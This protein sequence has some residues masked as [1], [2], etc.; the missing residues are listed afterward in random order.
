MKLTSAKFQ[1]NGR[2]PAKYT[3]LGEDINPLLNIENIP[4]G[5]QSLVLI[6]DDPDAPRGTFVHWVV[7]DIPVI[8]QIKED[9][10]PGTQ[11]VNDFKTNG[12]GGPC[13]P[14]GTH[15]YF[16]KIYAL[17]TRLNLPAGRTKAEIE[18]AMKG[19]VIAQDECIGLFS[20]EARQPV[21]DDV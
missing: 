1:N 19:H 6:V 3:C 7:Y 2:I 13:P 21:A 16:F 10:V 20:K 15:R 8:A 12:Y 5:T 17:D 18:T 14:S 9:S 4:Q 11:G